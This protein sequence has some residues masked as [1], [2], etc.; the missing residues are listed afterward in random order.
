MAIRT[1]QD[2]ARVLE[3]VEGYRCFF[4]NDGCI[5]ASLQELANC[6]DHMT[7]AI[8]NHHVTSSNNDFSNWILVVL[9]DSKLAADLTKASDRTEAAI[10][11]TKRIAWLQNKL[12]KS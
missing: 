7:E 12:R 2:A 4:C 6:M 8:Y 9:G 1:K 3:K 10:L 5:N 11:I